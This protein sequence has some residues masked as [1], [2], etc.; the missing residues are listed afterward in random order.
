VRILHRLYARLM[1]YFW[2]PCPACGKM[3]G[4]HEANHTRTFPF[5]GRSWMT[6]GCADFI[7]LSFD[8]QSAH[9]AFVAM[10]AEVDR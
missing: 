4:G 1:G 3:F 6:C 7:P 2:L 10:R 8:E 9:P 5:Q